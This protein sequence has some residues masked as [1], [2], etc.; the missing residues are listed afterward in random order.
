MTKSD[1]VARIYDALSEQ[2]DNLEKVAKNSC[3]LKEAV[4]FLENC[5][6]YI[7]C[8]ENHHD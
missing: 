1:K 5:L 7:E 6:D 3:E 2:R 4:V 8:W